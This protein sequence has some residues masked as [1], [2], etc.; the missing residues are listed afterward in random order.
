MAFVLG[1]TFNERVFHIFCIGWMDC[2]MLF[3]L[4]CFSL[5]ILLCN[6]PNLIEY[7]AYWHMG[8]HLINL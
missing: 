1:Y 4:Y 7:E 3:C 8:F 6:I 2:K 5:L